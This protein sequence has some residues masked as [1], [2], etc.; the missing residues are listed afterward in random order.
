MTL[1]LYMVTGVLLSGVLLSM[2]TSSA[3]SH[4]SWWR[5]ASPDATALVGIQWEHLR[6]SPFADAIS[7]ELSGDDGLGFPDLDC[8]KNARQI[9][10]SS[11]VLLAMAAGDFPAA[12]LRE[13]AARKGLKRAVYRDVEIWVTPGKETLS[14]ARMSD[15]LVL[16]GLL[17]NLQDAVDRSLL[18]EANR[19]SSPW[20]ARAAHYAQD[21]LWVVATGLPDTLADR[22]I[23]I[24][25]EAQGFEGGVSVQGGL[26]VKAAFTTSS[27]ESADRLVETLKGMLVTMPLATRGIEIAIDQNHVTLSMAVSEQQ[28][29][30]GLKTAATVVAKAA[31]KP[32]PKP[33]PVAAKPAAPQVIRIYG[34]DEGPREIVMR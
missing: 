16:L 32:E 14:I 27:E 26:K 1:R 5:Y 33:E 22:F 25:V 6:T 10:I 7:G 31:P 20:L 30:A 19:G 18:E 4:P 13:Q 17:K 12:T 24:D 11:P 9:V 34:L 21:D 29:A 2:G 8:L 15:Q 3:E 28:L 23:P